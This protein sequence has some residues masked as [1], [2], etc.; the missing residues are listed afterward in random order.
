M[1]WW[2]T[3][4]LLFDKVVWVIKLEWYGIEKTENNTKNIDIYE[5]I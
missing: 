5:E 1:E 2:V 4:I 3:D